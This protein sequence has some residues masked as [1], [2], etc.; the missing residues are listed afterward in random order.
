MSELSCAGCGWTGPEDAFGWRDRE[1]G[2]RRSRCRTC[3]AA[4][5]ARWYAGRAEA[6]RERNRTA[7]S[8]RYRENRQLV[9]QLKSRACADCGQRHPPEAMDFDHVRGSKTTDIGSAV[10]QLGADA[11]MTEIAKCEVVCA[12]CHRV[13]TTE[14]LDVTA[15][16]AGEVEQ[17][18]LGDPGSVESD[19]VGLT[20]AK[21]CAGCGLQRPLRDFHRHAGR[22]DGR[23]TFCKACKR[24]YNARYY[25][26]H[27]EQQRQR[28]K[29]ARRRLRLRRHS[30]L[31]SA[32]DQP[33]Q[34]CARRFPPEAMDFD[35][36]RGQKIGDI[37]SLRYHALTGLTAEIAKC[38]VV[39]A[40][41][42]RLRT[43]RRRL[44]RHRLERWVGP[45]GIEPRT[46]RLRV[47]CSAS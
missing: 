18:P 6:H 13:R 9:D 34:D 22:P 15:E 4:Q 20:E 33:C 39:C 42:H 37:S 32:V 2:R 21:R 19:D 31:R 1:N 36:V 27:E 5:Q 38:E 24:A 29:P 12:N 17:R 43:R 16:D 8:A 3:V 30:L 26:I 25:R 14:R 28:V 11:L 23:Q 35:H 44:R 40:N 46:V 41:C 10:W 7:R 45:R 47:E